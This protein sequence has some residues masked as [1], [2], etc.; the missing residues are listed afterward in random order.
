[1]LIY[2]LKMSIRDMIDV[3]IF[4]RILRDNTVK[5]YQ[6]IEK[7]SNPQVTK[8]VDKN[9]YPISSLGDRQSSLRTS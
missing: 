6:L 3:Q 2:L 9:S 4:N 8:V 5:L 1:M 7:R